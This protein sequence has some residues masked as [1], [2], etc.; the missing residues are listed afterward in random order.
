MF[1]RWRRPRIAL[2]AL[3]VAVGLGYTVD[4]L[5]S[6]R[7]S[8]S[9]TVAHAGTN[10]AALPVV[11]LSSLPVQAGQ[12]VR[13]IERGGPF[14]YAQDGV[15]FDNNEHLLPAH[16]RGYYHEYTVPTPGAD[17]RATRRIVTGKNGEFYYTSDHYDAFER[18]AMSS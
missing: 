12:T 17:D 2:V 14:P 18:I 16:Q 3:L 8:H 10:P 1:G 5:H 9:S 4:A 6:D 11:A 7:S 15:V 13:L